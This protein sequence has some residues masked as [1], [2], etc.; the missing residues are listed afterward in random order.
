MAEI[1]S[2]PYLHLAGLTHK[3]ALIAW[4]AFYFRVRDHDGDMKLLDDDDLDAIHPPRE[5]SIGA[6]SETY[7][8]AL[9]EVFD[10]AGVVV[11]STTVSS[12]NYC[13]V[14]NLEPNTEY[15]Y[16]VTVKGEVWARDIRRDWEIRDGRQGMVHT[17][18]YDNRF[19]TMPAPTES[20]TAPFTFAVIGDFGR[21]VRKPSNEERRQ[22][23][24]AAA[25]ERAVDEHDVRLLL[26]TGDNIYGKK[27]FGIFPAGSSGD[28]D[29]DWFFTFYQPYRYII[30]RIP[31]YPCIGNHDADESEDF[32]DRDQLYDNLYIRERVAA[33]IAVGRA[34]IDPGLFYRFRCGADIEFICLDTSK[35]PGVFFK[36]RL[37]HHPN[38]AAFIK[39]AFA[40]SNGSPAPRWRIPFAHHSPFS[41]GPRHKNNKDMIEH[42]VGKFEDGGVRAVFTGHEH[43]FQHAHH[44]GIDYFVTG[45]AGKVR[46][47]TPDSD[48]FEEAHTVSW[49]PTSHSLLVTIDDNRMTVRA[50]GELDEEGKLTEIK[51]STPSEDVIDGPMVVDVL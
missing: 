24:I 11:S 26:T 31:V 43:N 4:G 36:D 13:W 8:D 48:D 6:R 32:D 2:E 5:Q 44:G 10:S 46:T 29:D 16:V 1:H 35:E 42:L 51:R 25:L 23:E 17:R 21:G 22:R 34:S 9:V 14:H 49:A 28:E 38:H 37:F 27:F 15:R 50:I 47:G 19:R 40:N 41:A 20:L 33:D 45:G 12:Q 30:N 18:A 39:N 7:G 3:S